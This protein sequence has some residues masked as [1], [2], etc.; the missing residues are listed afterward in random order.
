MS[1]D[2]GMYII[3]TVA[4]NRHVGRFPIEDRSLRPKEVF[5][6]P[7]NIDVPRVGFFERNLFLAKPEL[8]TL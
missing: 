6:L 7:Q 2:S 8:I 3:T 4:D 1:L 5:A